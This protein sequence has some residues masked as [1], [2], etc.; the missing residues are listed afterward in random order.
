MFGYTKGT[1]AANAFKTVHPLEGVRRW[2]YSLG[3]G[4]K[5]RAVDKDQGRGNLVLS[6]RDGV[7]WPQD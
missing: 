7:S 2:F 3:S 4:I 5:I 1:T 6:F